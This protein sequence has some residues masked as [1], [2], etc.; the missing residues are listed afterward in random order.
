MKADIAAEGSLSGI[1]IGK[2]GP[3]GTGGSAQ[4]HGDTDDA[5]AIGQK[6]AGVENFASSCCDHRV[7]AIDREL[8]LKLLQI[9]FA[10]VVF[11]GQLDRLK[12]L[13]AQIKIEFLAQM[14]CG[15]TAT[16]QGRML[17]E[18]RNQRQTFL[19]GGLSA[20]HLGRSDGLHGAG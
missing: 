1:E 16:E 19:P 17:A 13:R 3:T 9:L 20:D 2:G 18:I 4:R 5:E 14:L 8:L 6:L 15:L 12:P 7:A 11:E 10:A